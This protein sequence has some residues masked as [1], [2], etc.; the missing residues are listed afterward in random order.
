LF[1]EELEAVRI[2]IDAKH[3]MRSIGQ[4]PG[5]IDDPLQEAWCSMVQEHMSGD[6]DCFFT[7]TYS[8]GYGYA[9]GLMKSHN[10]LKDFKR[11]LA[12]VDLDTSSWVCAVELHKFR[13]ILHVHA[14][15]SGAG[16]FD[17]RVVLEQFW[18]SSGRGLLVTAAPLLDR[19]VSYCTKYALKGQDA[20]TFDWSFAS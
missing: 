6:G 7:G 2:S 4:S 1:G 20:A 13:D 5:S 17:A 19:G 9:H 8:D 11:F 14:L 12:S 18:R 16:D 15:I 3:A 10:V